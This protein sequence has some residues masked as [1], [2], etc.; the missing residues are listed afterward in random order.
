[1]RAR[2]LRMGGL[3]L[4]AAIQRYDAL[5]EEGAKRSLETLKKSRANFGLKTEDK[6]RERPK[7]RP[8]RNVPFAASR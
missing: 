5:S 4:N 6:G 3:E 1:M 8:K 7:R 2:R